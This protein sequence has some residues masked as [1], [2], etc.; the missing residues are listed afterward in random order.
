[1]FHKDGGQPQMSKNMCCSFLLLIFL[2]LDFVVSGHKRQVKGAWIVPG[3]VG[4]LLKR[5]LFSSLGKINQNILIVCQP[6]KS[7]K[8]NSFTAFVSFQ[9][10]L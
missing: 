6:Q 5:N 7:R 10:I 2:L 1:M 8:R 3:H 4:E 9:S